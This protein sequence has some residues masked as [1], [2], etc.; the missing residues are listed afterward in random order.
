MLKKLQKISVLTL[1]FLLFFLATGFLTDCLQ[2]ASPLQEKLKGYFLIQVEDHGQVWYITPDS[3]EKILVENSDIAF[4]ILEKY[5]LGIKSEKLAEYLDSSFP[6]NFKAKIFLDVE[7]NGE[8][9][10]V[11]PID[12]KGWY[13]DNKDNIINIIGGFALGISNENLSKID[14]SNNGDNKETNNEDSELMVKTY[15]PELMRNFTRI[16][17]VEGE[18]LN[19]E[20][21]KIYEK[22]ILWGRKENLTLD[23]NKG[24][25][26]DENGAGKIN[27]DVIGLLPGTTNYI[28]AYVISG[29][30]V[31]YGN[32]ETIGSWGDP[33]KTP[34]LISVMN[35]SPLPTPPASE[36]EPEPEPEVTQYTLTYET[37]EGG[38]LDGETSQTVDEGSDGTAVT[39]VANLG[40]EFQGWTTFEACDNPMNIGCFWDGSAWR[41]I[42]SE[43]NPR[44]DTNVTGDITTT[45]VFETQDPV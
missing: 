23:N 37:T 32:E 31:F 5:G 42:D 30:E 9:Y 29:D 13:L 16:I 45:A 2:A 40:Y 18:V 33:N 25:I 15:K 43:E 8:A 11:N 12:M 41:L 26:E 34:S 10:Y 28:R 24:K 39:A 44:T 20:G 27:V 1:I 14:S 38:S 17:N 22:G 3:G 36:P 21:L 19:T 7:N 35:N 6:G 4:E